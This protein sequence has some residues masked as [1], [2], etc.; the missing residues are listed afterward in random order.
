MPRKADCHCVVNRP[1]ADGIYSPDHSRESD[2][3][4]RHFVTTL[5]AAGSAALLPR[6]LAFGQS[7]Q[8]DKI[9]LQLYTLRA[10]M[11]Q[12]VPRTLQTVAEVGYREVEFAG[13]F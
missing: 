5:A 11:G 10:M 2:M 12:S 3:D 7:A 6:E 9:G 13:Y 8:L 4:R 1:V